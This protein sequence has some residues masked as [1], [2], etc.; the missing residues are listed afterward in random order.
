MDEEAHME[1]T[2]TGELRSLVGTRGAARAAG[3]TTSAVWRG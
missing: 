3:S 1:R 2:L